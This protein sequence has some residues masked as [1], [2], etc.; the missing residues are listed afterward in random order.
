MHNNFNNYPYNKFAYA[1]DHAE[2]TPVAPW[3]PFL[4]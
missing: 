3:R 4:L 1:E 2:Y